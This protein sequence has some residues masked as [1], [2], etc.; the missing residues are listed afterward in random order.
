MVPD[1]LRGRVMSLYSMMF[2]GMTPLGSLLAGTI[3]AHV[4]APV[5]VAMGGV[6]SLIGGAFSRANGLPCARPRANWL[7]HKEC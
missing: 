4:G 7:Q 6:A 2:L 1:R 3:A 5:T